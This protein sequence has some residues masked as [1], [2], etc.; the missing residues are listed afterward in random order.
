MSRGHLALAAERGELVPLPE[1]LER[2]WQ[3]MRD[4]PEL[5]DGEADLGPALFVLE[6]GGSRVRA[7][8]ARE[9][10]V[11]ARAALVASTA[12]RGG[13]PHSPRGDRGHL[14]WHR[15]LG[16][17][18]GASAVRDV[19]RREGDV[20]LV[21]CG[22]GTQRQLLRSTLGL[23]ELDAILF[24]HFHADHVLGLPGLLKTYDL[25]GREHP[26]E[27]IGPTGL[28]DLMRI[29]SPFLGRLGYP[30]ELREVRTAMRS[31][32]TATEL[33]AARAC[34]IAARRSPGRSSR[35]AG[36][37]S[38][39]RRSPTSSACR[40]GPSAARSCAARR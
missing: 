2:A 16:A 23:T 25:Q 15:R 10:H 37:A 40:T 21:D 31:N 28:G 22:E 18:C 17:L 19:L 35:M 38:S 13:R 11:G 30:L 34:A 32:A 20:L 9:L 27:L 1:F 26:L 4:E 36:P 39:T 6:G 5:F 8:A 3:I 12:H 14:P 24:T 29:F 7:T 33:R